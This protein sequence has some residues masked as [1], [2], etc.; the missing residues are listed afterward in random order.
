MTSRRYSAARILLSRLYC[1][2]SHITW[3]VHFSSP[4]KCQV[5]S[6]T[7]E[8]QNHRVWPG[9]VTPNT[10]SFFSN[11]SWH[12]TKSKDTLS[13]PKSLVFTV[14]RRLQPVACAWGYSTGPFDESI[15]ITDEW[16]VGSWLSH[17]IRLTYQTYLSDWST[18]PVILTAQP[19]GRLVVY[20]N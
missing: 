16:D 15:W 2:P 9:H 12:L 3:L 6:K 10:F 5:A 20:P 14:L 13:R 4:I 17:I 8:N 7:V 1:I 11:V 18:R 19:P